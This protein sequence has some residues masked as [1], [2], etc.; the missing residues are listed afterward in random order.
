MSVS[1]NKYAA[2]T[3]PGPVTASRACDLADLLPQWI[4]DAST[5]GRVLVDNP[6]RLYR[7]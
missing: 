3:I 5:R 6:A 7:F 1:E 2:P 4:P